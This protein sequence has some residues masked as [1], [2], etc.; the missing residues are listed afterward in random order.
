MAF[1]FDGKVVLVTGAASGIGLAIARQFLGA[2]A[3][4]VATDIDAAALA[5]I[6]VEPDVAAR[7]VTRQLDAGSAPA[8]GEGI[9]WIE[10]QHGRLDALI[11]NAGLARLQS[12]AELSEDAIDLQFNV[13]LKGP[14]LAARAALPMLERSGGCIVNI[15]S[16]AAVIQAAGHA[17]YSACKAGLVK[18][19][20][21]LVKEHPGVRS[22]VILPGFIDTP[23][24]RAYGEGEALETIKRELATHIPLRRLGRADDIADAVLYLCSPYASY[25]SGAEL[26]VDGGVISTT[27]ENM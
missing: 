5:A 7:W 2:G 11:N 4:V 18:F 13:L 12:I 8:I 19:T 20:H 24:L 22:N 16:I 27:L 1:E 14:M 23:I 10:L 9:A 26:V 6:E 21:D 25:I 3:T 15:A 17:C